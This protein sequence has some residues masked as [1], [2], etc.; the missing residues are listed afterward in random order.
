MDAASQQ[1]AESQS[2]P[3][4]V[5]VIVLPRAAAA[6]QLGALPGDRQGHSRTTV[7][8][9]HRL[10]RPWHVGKGHSVLAVGGTVATSRRRSC[11]CVAPENN[12]TAAR[13]TSSWQWE[14]SW[15]LTGSGAVVASSPRAC[16]MAA[17]DVTD[18][19]VGAVAGSLHQ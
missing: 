16:I 2:R 1:Q 17:R 10:G 13:D 9:P 8:E 11:P 15:S 14:E 5:A 7:A 6:R 12:G 18:A 19:D 3:D 4:G